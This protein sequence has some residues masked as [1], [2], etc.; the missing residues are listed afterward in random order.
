MFTLAFCLASSYLLL[1]RFLRY[2]R[3]NGIT[4]KFSEDELTKMTPWTA[5]RIVFESFFYD[6]PMMMLLGTQVALFKVYGISS[7]ASL[8]L[9]T[10]ELR[11]PDT[12]NKRL[13]DT[14]TLIATFVSNPL[15]GAG[16]DS[17]S[18]DPRGAIAIARVSYLHR[19]YR[20]SNDDFLYNLALFMLEPIRWTAR[21]DWRPHSPIEVQAIF[22]LWTEIG[23]RM[24]IQ[25]IW[26]SYGEMEEWVKN[27][28]EA[29]MIPS[30]A[31]EE[32]A[33][34][35][36]NHFLARIRIKPLRRVFFQL[37]CTVLDPRTRKAMNLPDPS[38][39]A[40][41]LIPKLFQIRAF[42]VRHLCLP[43]RK[44]SIWVQLDNSFRL[45]ERGVPRM[46]AVY[47]KRSGPYYYPEKTGFALKVQNFLIKLGLRNAEKMPGKRWFSEGYRLEEL[48]PVR[49]RTEG[50]EQVFREAARLQ[51]CPIT[52]PWA[53]VV[54]SHLEKN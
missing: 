51:G 7:I 18:D 1:V 26:S 40:S 37:M 20:I 16:Y 52:G 8:L 35:T 44:P 10:G 24:G 49:F 11:T 50:H 13:A 32:L 30:P 6:T 54:E 9:Q 19:K 31:S 12:L 48:G 15:I 42:F 29:N 33:R 22:V 23:R 39:I 14:S 5:Q 34:L 36:S 4:S 28:E 21:F 27:Y 3:V 47:Q 17:P 53:P 45:D 38:P 46:S 41:F 2:R 25:D 43:R